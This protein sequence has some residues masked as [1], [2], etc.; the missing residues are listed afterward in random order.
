MRLR[1]AV[2]LG[3]GWLRDRLG[4][5]CGLCGRRP[6]VV[7]QDHSAGRD[8]KHSATPG[9]LVPTSYGVMGCVSKSFLS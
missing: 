8:Q 2:I 9:G 4:S 1:P 6:A 3:L 7:F 5:H